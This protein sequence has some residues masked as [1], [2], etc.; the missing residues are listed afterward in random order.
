MFLGSSPNSLR[1][2]NKQGC[3]KH[4][5]PHPATAARTTSP[6]SSAHA[7]RSTPS[8]PSHYSCRLCYAG[9]IVWTKTRS[10]VR[11]WQRPPQGP[12]LPQLLSALHLPVRK[13]ILGWPGQDPLSPVLHEVQTSG[14]PCKLHPPERNVGGSSGL[15]LMERIWIGF[16]L[17]VLPDTWDIKAY[18]PRE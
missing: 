14:A 9:A 12:S 2:G 5:Q 3:N 18:F 15:R 17:E 10:P 6:Q 11:L 1:Q 8:A 4:P 13:S 16:H 7:V